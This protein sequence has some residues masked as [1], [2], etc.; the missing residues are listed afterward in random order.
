M[1]MMMM[2]DDDGIW[3]NFITHTLV[4]WIIWQG[5]RRRRR[6]SRGW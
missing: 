3:S 6:R 5:R 1:I 4:A 2:D